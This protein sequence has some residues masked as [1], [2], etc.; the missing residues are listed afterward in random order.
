[1]KRLFW[2]IGLLILVAIAISLR[3]FHV[4]GNER[5]VERVVEAVQH[6]NMTPVRDAFDAAAQRSMTYERVGRLADLL[7]PMGKLVSIEEIVPKE[8]GG[9]RVYVLHFQHGDW[10]A[11]M[12]LDG[13]GKV[14]GFAMQRM[15]T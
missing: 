10:R 5:L 12:P 9:R 15:Q 7:A 1:M 6:N 8:T 3:S 2:A 4:S 14:T 13:H 11:M